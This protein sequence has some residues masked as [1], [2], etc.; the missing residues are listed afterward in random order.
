MNFIN[1]IRSLINS[2]NNS[3]NNPNNNPNNNR[4]NYDAT[5][6]RN[7]EV[8]NYLNNVIFPTTLLISDSDY[9]FQPSLPYRIMYAYRS[10]HDTSFIE[11]F[12]NN[13]ITNNTHSPKKVITDDELRKLK[14]ITFKKEDEINSNIECPIMC[15]EFNENEEIIKL[16]CQHN[17]NK[18]AILKWLNEESHTC[19][20]CRYKFE[21]KEIDSSPIMINE[22]NTYENNTDEN[23]TDENNTDENNTDENNTDENNTDE[24][25]SDE[26]NTDQNENTI[27]A[28]YNLFNSTINSTINS[29]NFISVDEYMMQE[30]LLNSFNSNSN[31][32]SNSN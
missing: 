14:H 27:N 20:V 28:F 10:I 32:N 8:S 24:N 4:N 6:L 18:E 25:N 9:E 21:Y 5:I 13:T 30:I 26:N 16:P 3:N 19:P 11:N 7:Q 15:Y 2:N 22:N 17:Y 29:T 1:N 23:N 12:I 31:S